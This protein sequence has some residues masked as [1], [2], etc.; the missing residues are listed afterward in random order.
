MKST[1]RFG[2]K[3]FNIGMFLGNKKAHIR[4]HVVSALTYGITKDYLHFVGYALTWA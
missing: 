3:N 4:S 1:N 2:L